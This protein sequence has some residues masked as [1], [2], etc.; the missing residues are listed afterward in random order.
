MNVAELLSDSAYKYGSGP[1][2]IYRDTAIPFSIFNNQVARLATALADRGGQA[3][4]RI[5]V[6]SSNRP[7]LLISLFAAWSLGAVAVPVNSALAP[8]E[9]RAVIDH[10]EPA[11]I[12][13]EKDLAWVLHGISARCPIC[14]ID[15]EPASEWVRITQGS[16]PLP[17]IVAR[18]PDDLALIYYTSG[19]TGV[20]KGVMLSQQAVLSTAR[21]FAAHL[22]V[23]PRDR[24]LIT[25]PMAFILHLTMNALTML[26]GGASMVIMEKFH[27]EQVFT[28]IRRHEVSVVTAVPT[29]YIMMLNWLE[30]RAANIPSLKVAV[31]AGAS[32]PD[33]LYQRCLDELGLQVCDL[34]GMSECGPIA[35]YSPV[36]DDQRRSE[37]C[38]RT[39]GTCRLRIVDDELNDLPVGQVGEVLARSPGVLTGYFRNPQSTAEVLADGWV[40]SG[41]LGRMDGD[42]YLYIVGRK[43]DLI[44]RG[45]TNIFP[46]D[47]EEV[48]YLHGAVQ[49]CAVVGMPD[50][51]F[52]EIVK[53]FVVLRHGT[54]AEPSDI[55]EHCRRKMAEYKV[56]SS[57][58]FI[59]ELPKGPTGKILRRQL[60]E[61]AG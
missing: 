14:I 53:A 57:V 48:I 39:I 35:S 23:T 41:D 21:M 60:V 56:P 58:A 4:A 30:G 26:A 36:I 29:A 61:T 22:G 42:G 38:G 52:G 43:K 6:L 2:C 3:G 19:T 17:R 13:V 54:T 47:V 40:R 27:P 50:Q 37:S 25:G 11:V 15:T 33:A 34:W 9:V 16:A 18:R 45:G 49:E 20:P 8:P 1:V 7:E 46:S 28:Q 5:V 10:C 55:I 51:T 44:I 32:F 31:S 24:S 59:D 12:V